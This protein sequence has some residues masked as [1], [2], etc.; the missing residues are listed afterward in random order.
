MDTPKY[1][2]VRVKLTGR[3]GN[4]FGIIGRVSAAL[5]KADVPAAEVS[6]YVNES[7]SGDYANVLRTAASWVEV[8]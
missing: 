1:P 5:R 4:A 7:M 3:D 2:D 6:Q 8:R